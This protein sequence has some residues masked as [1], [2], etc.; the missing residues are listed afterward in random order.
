MIDFGGLEMIINFFALLYPYYFYSLQIRS[1]FNILKVNQNCKAYNIHL[2]FSLIS[3][4]F[5][6][7]H[8]IACHLLVY[9]MHHIFVAIAN[10]MHRNKGQFTSSKTKHEDAAVS[11]TNMDTPQH[12]ADVEGRPQSAPM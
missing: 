8:K 4:L 11:I 6:T 12:W 7:Q 5:V 3:F 2:C 9:L 1:S 10:R